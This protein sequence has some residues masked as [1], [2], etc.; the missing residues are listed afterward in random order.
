MKE[1][2]PDRAEA[3]SQ[4]VSQTFTLVLV[5]I[6]GLRGGQRILILVLHSFSREAA[7]QQS[8]GVP[9]SLPLPGHTW[10]H[11]SRYPVYSCSLFK[12]FYQAPVLGGTLKPVSMTKPITF[13]M[14]LFK[15]SL[16]TFQMDRCSCF[17]SFP[18][19]DY[20]SISLLSFT[21]ILFLVGLDFFFIFIGLFYFY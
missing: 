7:R 21:L 13:P 10:P 2:S 14:F 20:H 17:I 9:T 18:I 8:M 19:W 5:Q 4:W 3:A 1:I 6:S 16:K 11:L 12:V 15:H